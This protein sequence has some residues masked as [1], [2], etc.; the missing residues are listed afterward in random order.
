MIIAKDKYDRKDRKEKLCTSVVNVKTLFLRTSLTIF[1]M[2]W[3]NA[4]DIPPTADEDAVPFA[5][6]R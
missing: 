4:G 5:R 3:E 2:I 1:P 6:V